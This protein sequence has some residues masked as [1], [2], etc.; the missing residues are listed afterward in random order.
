VPAA[1]EFISDCGVTR[2]HTPVLGSNRLWLR[3]ETRVGFKA[4]ENQTVQIRPL[5]PGDRSRIRD[6]V[7]ASGNFTEEEIAVA[8]ELVDS[9]LQD[10]EA[11]G[12]IIVVLEDRTRNP[13]VQGY[14]CYGLTP[15][16]QG[17]Y[18]LYWIAVDPKAQGGGFGR[19]LIHFVEDE[20][21]RR[22]G[23]MVLI[24]TSSQE[25]YGGTIRFYERS[26]YELV[27]RIR[28]FYRVGDDK[29]IFQKDLV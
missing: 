5:E 28:N 25:S 26:G 10:G 11:S 21:M 29:L 8:Q 16:T 6:I 12:Y 22:G 7:T 2:D 1:G 19:K 27:A 13:A 15:L 18:D 4:M 9:A 14:A 20:V 24:E 17:V 3:A 23:R